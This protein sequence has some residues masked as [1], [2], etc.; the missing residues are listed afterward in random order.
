M[1][2]S[3]ATFLFCF[4]P[5]T[6]LLYA[7]I[8]SKGKNA[9]LFAASLLFYAFGAR[10]QTALLLFSA[11][12]NWMIGLAIGRLRSQK[13]KKALLSASVAVNLSLLV[14][15]KYSAF[16]LSLV[17][18]AFEAPLLPIGISFYTF[19]AMSYTVDVY[20]GE[21][22]AE[23]SLLFFA[24]YLCLFPQLIAGPIVRYSDVSAELT[25]RRHTL[26][27][28]SDGA[29]R[30]AVGLCKKVIVADSLAMLVL[31]FRENTPTVLFAWLYAIAFTL[32][33]YYDFS[34]YSDMAIGLGQLFGFH[35]PTNF[36]YPYFAKSI[37][38]F[39]RRWH[40][41]LSSWFK[42][43]VY[44]P[45]GGN[46]RGKVRLVLNLTVVWLL[47]GLWHGSAFTFLLWGALY[48]L[49]LIFEKFGG[50]SLLGRLPSL[51]G[52][53]YTLFFVTLG[54]VIFNAQSLNEA[55]SDIGALFKAGGI[56]FAD[57]RSLYYLK[58]YLPLLLFSALAATPL[59]KK[60]FSG[61]L[62]SKKTD[63]ESTPSPLISWG[64][65]FAVLF[66]TLS[67]AAFAV[68]ESYRPFLYFQF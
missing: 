50:L 42:S 9:L 3:S 21:V 15:F 56:P 66:L 4:L 36:N 63:P 25:A 20:R 65:A 40:I 34:G 49:L 16:F 32:E 58:S 8:P 51:F 31:L 37:T 64:K 19:Q 27:A 2:F 61:R 1:L 18:I 68:S 14:Y 52:R 23:K 46:R 10:E 13:G 55:L 44:I 47:T 60:L 35:F 11:F 45:L 53:L 41:T 22:Q 33:I 5:L 39:W 7:V 30:F 67:G 62:S 26:A 24:T 6:L 38:D 48:A 12:F 17:G 29:F 54:F 59:P 28:F 43:Y 57:E